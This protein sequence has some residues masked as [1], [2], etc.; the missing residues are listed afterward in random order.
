MCCKKYD[1]LERRHEFSNF[2]VLHFFLFLLQIAKV[3]VTRGVDA[4]GVSN[5]DV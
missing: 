4:L 1:K 2:V 5:R 3:A